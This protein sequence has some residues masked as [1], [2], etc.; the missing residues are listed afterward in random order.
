MEAKIKKGRAKKSAYVTMIEERLSDVNALVVND[1][2]GLTV[3]QISELRRDIAS[4]GAK[5]HVQK[6]KLAKIAFANKGYPEELQ[7]FLVGPTALTYINGDV[8]PVL[9][10]L[11]KYVKDA[12]YS[13]DIKGAYADGVVLNRHQA[14]MVST[15]PSREQLLA[16]LMG[17]LN[18]P[19]RNVMRGLND[20][21][22]RMARVLQSIAD[23]KK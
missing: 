10:K 20:V 17:V 23:K 1:Y 4:L 14:E 3:S 12:S 5:M 16:T 6:N 19:V 22:A 15:L 9:Q 11:F 7:Q 8:S 2:R 18:A 13:F 21:V